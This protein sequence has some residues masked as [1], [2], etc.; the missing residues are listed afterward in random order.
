MLF[1]TYEPIDE[2]IYLKVYNTLGQIVA[3]HLLEASSDG[4]YQYKLN[5]N[6]HASGVYYVRVGTSSHGSTKKI[7][8][9]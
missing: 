6:Y 2:N 8:V 4:S 7:I 1:T 5:M 9:Q 3:Q